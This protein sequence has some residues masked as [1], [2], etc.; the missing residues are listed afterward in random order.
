MRNIL[1]FLLLCAGVALV[2]A[3]CKEVY[4]QG[5]WA[6]LLELPGPFSGWKGTVGGLTA[7]AGVT[8]A[9]RAE[10][11]DLVLFALVLAIIAILMHVVRIL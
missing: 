4:D 6:A 10:P 11:I 7:A 9:R 1:G 5:G 8:L 3:S 2:F